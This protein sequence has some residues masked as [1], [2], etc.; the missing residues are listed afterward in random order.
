MNENQ[1]NYDDFSL[2]DLGKEALLA[3][4]AT[5]TTTPWNDEKFKGLKTTLGCSRSRS[6]NA[7]GLIAAR[8]FL[9]W[10]AGRETP[11]ADVV[12]CIHVLVDCFTHQGAPL[13]LDEFY[14]PQGQQLDLTATSE[15]FNVSSWGF[16]YERELTGEFFQPKVNQASPASI[17]RSECKVWFD[18]LLSAISESASDKPGTSKSI[19]ENSTIARNYLAYLGMNMLRLANK[20]TE[21]VANHVTQFTMNSFTSIYGTKPPVECNYSA[22]PHATTV[23]KLKLDLDGNELLRKRLLYPLVYG[24]SFYPNIP[25][26]IRGLYVASFLLTINCNGL[27]T[28]SWSERAIEQ[29][30]TTRS[31]LCEATF[32]NATGKFW[33]EFSEFLKNNNKENTWPF[34]RMFESSAFANFAVN[35]HR[36][37]TA[38]F[39]AIASGSTLPSDNIW[40]TEH[41]K[42]L[43]PVEIL[44][45]IKYALA[46]FEE[47]SATN[48][49]SARFALGQKIIQKTQA[50]S[51]IIPKAF[52]STYEC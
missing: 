46:T 1:N 20:T 27:S 22:P 12:T 23:K 39:V 14:T 30:G 25:Q 51:S 47:L 45:G 36:Q 21:A 8:N 11:S 16:E 2:A 38:I 28:L 29:L 44:M 48:Y 19:S 7:L 33:V 35:K 10:Y 49:T 37:I 52:G 13:I 50:P 31:K 3:P 17:S 24:Y 9:Y 42:S 6:V 5:L 18:Q 43:T 15:G 41:L 40:K 32:T 34:A 4:S 26:A